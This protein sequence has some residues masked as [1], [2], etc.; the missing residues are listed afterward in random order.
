MTRDE[1]F[2]MRCTLQWLSER[3]RTRKPCRLPQTY[4]MAWYLCVEEGLF[5]FVER[6]KI[7]PCLLLPTLHGISVIARPLDVHHAQQ[8]Q[9]V[10]ELIN[11]ISLNLEI[12]KDL[13][14]IRFGV[15]RILLF[16]TFS[17]D[18]Q[19]SLQVIGE[20]GWRLLGWKVFFDRVPFRQAIFTPRQEELFTDAWHVRNRIRDLLRIGN[21]L[22]LLSRHAEIETE[23]QTTVRQLWQVLIAEAIVAGVCDSGP[24][25]LVA[26]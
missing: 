1:E 10:D 25:S 8:G 19:P 4:Q 21:Q 23:C 14:K 12:V 16:E 11:S 15:G 17:S 20:I 26:A 5:I 9:G 18:V 6:P 22:R 3:E 13:A 24:T 7:V 2:F